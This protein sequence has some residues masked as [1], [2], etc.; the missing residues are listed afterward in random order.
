MKF[1][2]VFALVVVACTNFYLNSATKKISVFLN[3][4]GVEALAEQETHCLGD[5][6]KNSGKCKAN[7]GT[8][9]TGASCVAPGFWDDKDCYDTVSN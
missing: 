5:P 4:A 3:F 1:F 7:E 6:A 8:T 9:I 2:I